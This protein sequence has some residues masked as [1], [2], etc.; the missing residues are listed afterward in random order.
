MEWLPLIFTAPAV[1]PRQPFGSASW[2]FVLLAA[3]P[4][5]DR[6]TYN[7]GQEVAKV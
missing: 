3:F 6:R 2:P 4:G 1:V 7:E 5:E